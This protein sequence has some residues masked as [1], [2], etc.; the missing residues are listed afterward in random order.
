MSHL[1]CYCLCVAGILA[2]LSPERLLALGATV[3]SVFD[4]NPWLEA[5]KNMLTYMFKILDQ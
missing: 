5:V 4:L 3:A 2:G 1:W